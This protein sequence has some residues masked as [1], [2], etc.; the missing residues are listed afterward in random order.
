MLSRLGGRAV[1]DSGDQ[2]ANVF[3]VDGE[4][5]DPIHTQGTSIT[6][7][8]DRIGQQTL[9]PHDENFKKTKK[10]GQ[11]GFGTVWLCESSKSKAQN[12]RRTMPKKFALKE[13]SSKKIFR[14]GV[15]GDIRDYL[16]L[17]EPSIQRFLKHNTIV[18]TYWA[19]VRC[20]DPKTDEPLAITAYDLTV[21]ADGET[22]DQ[23]G[24]TSESAS[25]TPLDKLD[26]VDRNIKE[27]TSDLAAAAGGM[28][29]GIKLQMRIAMEHCDLGSL[30]DYLVKPGQATKAL[31]EIT[32]KKGSSIDM[33]R[34]I[35]L[36]ALDI[37]EALKFMHRVNTLHGDLKPHNILL[38]HDK[39]DEKQFRAKVSDFGLSAHMSAGETCVE[40]S[41]GTE[42]Y[43]PL[44][45]FKEFAVTEASDI[46]ALGL[47]MWE[48]YYGIFW[49]SVWDAEKKRRRARTPFDMDAYRPSCSNTCPS[50]FAM[51]VHDCIKSNPEKRPSAAEV[52]SRLN[53]ALS[54]LCPL[55]SNRVSAPVPP[56]NREGSVHG[57]TNGAARIGSDHQPNGSMQRRGSMQTGQGENTMAQHKG[58]Q[59]ATISKKSSIFMRCFRA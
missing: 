38:V 20:L 27:A 42:A 29:P 55:N 45:V 17:N 48:A 57:S 16:P 5:L 12:K 50:E 44:E 26:R 52:C 15:S 41:Q 49:F 7:A 56:P 23:G 37:A 1:H 6:G 18:Q 9:M 53:H 33:L 3:N 14:P 58:G 36:T 13:L 4:S 8:M 54:T 22:T 11:G 51:I 30:K 21:D 10:L 46:Y 2:D 39:H 25:W 34:C 31:S 43:L 24:V 47:L 59:V 40:I 19:D 28:P 35:L 32:R